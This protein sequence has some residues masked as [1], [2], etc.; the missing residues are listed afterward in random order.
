MLELETP[1]VLDLIEN[2]AQLRIANEVIENPRLRLI[3]NGYHVP[4]IPNDKILIEP[5]V[6]GRWDI[7]LIQIRKT[8][9]DPLLQ[10]LHRYHRY[11]RFS[12]SV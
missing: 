6:D 3:K 10:I 11:P 4:L 7:G 1:M 2:E 9:I 5:V 8:F 12:Q